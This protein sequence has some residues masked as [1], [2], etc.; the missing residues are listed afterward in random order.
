MASYQKDCNLG[1]YLGTLYPK[2]LGILSSLG[3]YL[4]TASP[5]VVV[6]LVF[7]LLVFRRLLT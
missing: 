1:L 4:E 6:A 7:V 3:D 5:V 2:Y